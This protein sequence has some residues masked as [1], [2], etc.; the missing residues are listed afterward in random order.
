MI[1]PSPSSTNLVMAAYG[2]INELL[3]SNEE[4]A[5]FNATEFAVR[6]EYFAR[7]QSTV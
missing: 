1:F 5:N 3:C 2:P 7:R 4:K 6:R